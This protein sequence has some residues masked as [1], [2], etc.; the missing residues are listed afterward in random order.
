MTIALLLLLLLVSQSA[1]KGLIIGI[2]G[3][4][5]DALEAVFSPNLDKLIAHVI[6]R[7]YE[8]NEDIT[9]SGLGR[10]AILCGVWSAKHFVTNN[11]FSSDN[12]AEYPPI[13]QRIGDNNP[14]LNTV[15]ICHW[16]YKH[17]RRA[18]SR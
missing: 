11:S 18:V 8:L 4:R 17:R 13:F 12:Y 2:D 7:P 3:F 16:R 9:M 10:S 15:A 1:S 14:D 5:P 6:Y